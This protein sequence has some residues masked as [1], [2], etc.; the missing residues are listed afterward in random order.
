V[1]KNQPA[2]I[3]L[4]PAS[5]TS[6]DAWRTAAQALFCWT[7][8]CL[9]NRDD[10][11]GGH[12][13]DGR[14][15]T[16]KRTLGM[17]QIKEHFSGRR[18]IGLHAI[19]TQNTC[20]WVT[21]DID[22]HNEGD[23]TAT[24][25]FTVA[26]EICR[27]ALALGLHPILSDS[28]GKGGYHVQII[29]N[30]AIPAANAYHFGLWL[31]RGHNPNKPGGVEVFPK[32]P[33]RNTDKGFGGGWVRLYGKHHKRDHWTRVWDWQRQ[34]WLEGSAAIASLWAHTGDDPA[35][36]SVVDYMPA[37]VPPAPPQPPRTP[38]EWPAGRPTDVIDQAR[39]YLTKLPPAVSG[40]R[41]HDATFHAS[42]ILVRGFDLRPSDALPL[43][44][45]WNVTCQPSWSDREL[46]HKLTDADKAS[47]DRPRGYLIWKLDNLRSPCGYLADTCSCP[48]SCVLPNATVRSNK[49][50]ATDPQSIRNQSAN[51]CW[52]L[53]K[54]IREK[55]ASNAWDCPCVRGVA[56]LANLSPA[57]IA[58]T[59]RKR[60][61][62]VC[63]P[64]WCLQT[65]DRFGC[66]LSGHD[67]QLYTDTV[68]DFDWQA[69]HKDMSRRARKLGVPLRYVA[70]RNKEG[71]LLTIIASVPIRP[72]VAH[73]VELSA[74]LDI[75]ERAI[76]D[77]DWGPRPFSACRA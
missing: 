73:P 19:S 71:D 70:M 77:A 25:N 58:A 63:R 37:A 67:G 54:R 43:L 38:Q 13:D 61:C 7:F 2:A 4:S 57:L 36:L 23:T 72:D 52:K 6:V 28:N 29:F 53:P 60:S 22:A 65:Y 24:A 56:G 42:C 45:E 3:P 35:K 51:C 34:R 16:A 18:I 47:D 48:D 32:R 10:A 66:H 49:D 1:G 8:S 55:Y 21:I 12:C 44:Q 31:A 26:L 75:L 39:R 64:Y 5:V 74:A 30:R 14:R 15:F 20:R 62:P 46:W 33:D 41:G 50:N 59:C 17:K 9:V 76:D 69:I 40:Q 11:S 68:S 27:R